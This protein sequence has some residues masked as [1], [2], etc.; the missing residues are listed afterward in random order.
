MTKEELREKWENLTISDNFMFS[1]V[2]RNEENCKEVLKRI[3]PYI[4]VGDVKVIEYEK[5]I[6]PTIIVT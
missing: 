2:M 6:D 1:K 3:L 5:V 4:K